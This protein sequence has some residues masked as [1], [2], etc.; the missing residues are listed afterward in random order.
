MREYHALNLGAGVQSTTVALLKDGDFDVAIF[1][2]T[3]EEPLSVYSHLRWLI[4]TLKTPVW[5]RTVGKLGDDLKQGRNSTGQR[6][7]SIP[8]YTDN[9]DRTDHIDVAT[10]K[11]RRQCSRE[12]KT[13]PIIKAIRQ[14]LLGLKPRQRWP[15]DVHLVQYFGISRDEAGRALRIKDR[16]KEQPNSEARFPLLELGWTRADCIRYL[17]DKIPHPVPKSACVFCPYHDDRAWLRMKREDPQSWARAV[18]IDEALR[19]KGN[20]VNRNMNQALYIHRSGKPLAEAD[21]N[22]N[23]RS[24]GFIKECEGVCGV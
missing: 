5:I 3:Q 8:A 11:T 6:F 10:G 18:E 4:E 24:I 2:D 16:V 7:A 22:E 14:E 20:I 9:G 12:Y 21:L 13:E 15:K 17:E 1:A 23:Q 19:I